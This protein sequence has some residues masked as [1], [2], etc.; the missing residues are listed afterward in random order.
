MNSDESLRVYTRR[1]NRVIDH[2]RTNLADDLS[3]DRLSNVANFSKYYFHRIF[4]AVTGENVNAF[5]GRLRI[6]KSA[7]MLLYKETKGSKSFSSIIGIASHSNGLAMHTR[8]R[9]G[10]VK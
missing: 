6:E 10:N 1:I 4:K 9:G 5:V 3:L 2:I 7:F 8:I